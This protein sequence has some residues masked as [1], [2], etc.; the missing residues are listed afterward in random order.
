[1]RITQ[2]IVKY[3]SQIKQ[4]PTH[5]QHKGNTC[6]IWDYSDYNTFQYKFDHENLFSC[7]WD[8]NQ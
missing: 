3:E 1:M 8:N 7:F 6:R 5:V 4:T 2:S